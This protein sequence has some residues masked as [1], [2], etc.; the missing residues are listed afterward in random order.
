[1]INKIPV[2]VLLLLSGSAVVLGDV[3][4]KYWSI[5]Q[6]SFLFFL[7]VA[8]YMTSSILYL[9]TLLREG[10]I[11]TSIIW[12]LFAIIGFLFV[13]LVVFKE[14]LNSTQIVGV[15]LGVISLIILSID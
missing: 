11:I 2:I 1:M 6:R 10:L 3:F 8:S 4:A 9:P 15:V 7:A 5:N 14:T 13:G 12:S